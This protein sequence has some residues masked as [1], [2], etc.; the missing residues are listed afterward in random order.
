[1]NTIYKPKGRAGEYG[2]YALNI[3]DGCPHGCI[4]CFVPNC[5]H[6]DRA[7]FHASC[8][9]RKN[10]VEETAKRLS[11]GDIK[12]KHIFLNFT[13]DPFPKGIDH[14]PTREIIRLI[15]DS[16]NFVQALTKGELTKKDWDCFKQGDIFG[17]TISCDNDLALKVEPYAELP[18]NRIL[19]LEFAKNIRLQTFISCE[20][21]F[22]TNVIYNLIRYGG[23]IDEYKIGKLNY[24]SAD[25][26]Y[27]PNINW[28][29]FGRE[30]E[31]L[32]K[33][34]GRNYYIKESLRK[35]M[36]EK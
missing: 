17:V 28:G 26:P 23:K 7:K 14:E 12:S 4:Y 20:P 8:I 30:C 21:I 34:Y 31:R 25:N 24:M 1:M 13:C 29:E 19:Q 16:G 2:E 9:S 3:Y 5:V 6:K 33:E 22:E 27:Y 11:K 15:H 36:E 32:C 35:A 18:L 10:I